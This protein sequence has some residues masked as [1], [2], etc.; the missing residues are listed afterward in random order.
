MDDTPSIL[1]LARRSTRDIHPHTPRW[2]AHM[3]AC[4]LSGCTATG[5]SVVAVYQNRIPQNACLDHNT[6]TKKPF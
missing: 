4:F 2:A 1:A 3:H 5:G 6:V